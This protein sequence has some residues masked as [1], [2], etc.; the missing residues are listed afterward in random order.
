M[1]KNSACQIGESG[2]IPELGRS[3]GGGHGNP[4]QYSC[5][6]SPPGQRSLVGYS[7]WGRK[8]SDTTERLSVHASSSQSPALFC[9]MTHLFPFPHSVTVLQGLLQE[10][11]EPQ[12]LIRFSSPRNYWL[13]RRNGPAA[14]GQSYAFPSEWGRVIR[15][16]ASSFKHQMF[17]EDHTVS[18]AV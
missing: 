4:L 3:P 14:L 13:G 10:R 18:S 11:Q 12:F 2:S 6:A 1:V 9:Y 7:P 15:M 16:F 17:I 5:L 8:E